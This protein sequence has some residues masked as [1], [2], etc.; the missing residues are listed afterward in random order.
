LKTLAIS[1]KIFSSPNKEWVI[2]AR[3]ERILGNYEPT[4]SG[5]LYEELA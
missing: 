4:K 5:L 2:E 1:N 3:K